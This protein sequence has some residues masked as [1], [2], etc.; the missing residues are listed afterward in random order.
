MISGS[1]SKSR[2]VMNGVPQGLVLV[3]VFFNIFVGDM[4]SGIKCILSKFEDD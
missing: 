1:V 2:M 3:P 4:D